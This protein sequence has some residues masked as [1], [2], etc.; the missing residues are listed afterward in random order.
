MDLRGEH[1]NTKQKDPRPA[2]KPRTFVLQG[3]CA[4]NCTTMQSVDKAKQNKI[5]AIKGDSTCF[6]GFFS[7]Y[8]IDSHRN[9]VFLFTVLHPFLNFPQ[10]AEHTE[11]D[12]KSFSYH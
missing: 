11:V 7:H 6:N 8:F 10:F 9:F 5:V 1:A 4:H 2:C 3:S 12:C